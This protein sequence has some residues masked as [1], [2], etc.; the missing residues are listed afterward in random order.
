MNTF[1]DDLDQDPNVPTTTAAVINLDTIR[2]QAHIANGGEASF[3]CKKC[4]GTGSWRVGY[5]CFACKGNGKVSARQLG[6]QKATET[7]KANEAAFHDTHRAEIEFLSKNAEWSDFY[8]SLWN[9]YNDRRTL[10]DNQLATVRNGMAKA[11]AREE[12]KKT[13]QVANSGTIELSAI[14]KLFATAKANGLKKPIWRAA[15]M[16]IHT[17]RQFG[18]NDLWIKEEAAGG[19]VGKIVNGEFRAFRR[20]GPDTLPTLKAIAADPMKAAIAYGQATNSCSCC[21]RTLRAGV[22]VV[23]GIGPICAGH[24]GLQFVRDEAEDAIANGEV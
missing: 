13:A 8:R 15:G 17:D 2:Q 6:A 18:V 22:S 24:W 11:A 9:Q 4:G 16:S 3:P 5:S 20:A 23:A 1:F 19:Y 7:R 12:A 14:D 10:S 21:G